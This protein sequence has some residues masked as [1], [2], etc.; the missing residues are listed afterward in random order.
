MDDHFTHEN[1]DSVTVDVND[2]IDIAAQNSVTAKFYTNEGLE[3][4]G[5]LYPAEQLNYLDSN[6]VSPEFVAFSQADGSVLQ[7]QE[8]VLPLDDASSSV[9][10]FNFVDTFSGRVDIM[11][12]IEITD[13]Y[14]DYAEKVSER[15][16]QYLQ[17]IIWSLSDPREA[18]CARLAFAGILTVSYHSLLLAS[19]ALFY[20][21]CSGRTSPSWW[22][23]LSA[24]PH[25]SS[26]AASSPWRTSPPVSFWRTSAWSTLTAARS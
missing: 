20:H 26:A 14:N 16:Q 6:V 12:K 11:L 5:I 9:V 24:N 10:A 21:Q 23:R 15:S 1:G 2:A 18:Q 4:Y 22:T 25:H 13:V 8:W 19:L 7:K 3:S 17:A